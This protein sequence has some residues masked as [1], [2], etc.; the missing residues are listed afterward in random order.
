MSSTC[1]IR[2]CFK[3]TVIAIFTFGAAMSTHAQAPDGYPN[4]PIKLV[5]P[6][7]AAGST[8][9]VARIVAEGLRSTLAQSVVV[10]NKAG[11]GGLLGT[12]AV[13]QAAPDGYTI[14][15]ATVSTLTVNPLV[16]ARGESVVS[17]VTPV[18]NLVTM[19]GVYMVH[20]KLGVNTFEALIAKAK[21]QPGKVT[22]GVP[23]LGTLGHLMVVALNETY[24]TEFQI[25]PYRGAAPAMTDALAGMIDVMPDQLPSAMPHI[26]GGKLIP[27]VQTSATRSADLPNVPTFKELGQESLNSLSWFGLVVPKNTPAHIVKTLQDAAVKAVRLPQVRERLKALGAAPT[28][29]DQSKFPEQISQQL[30]RNKVLVDKA[31]VK[32]E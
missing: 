16:F 24:K 9:V 17:R 8:D 4:K 2:K 26:K 3:Y 13:A 11:A 18:V 27:L 7:A 32:P 15:M 29:M 19:P 14:G 1:L 20:P 28:E 30:R 25:V 5:V 6:F 23:G 10:E 31:G 22:V 12:E 21:E